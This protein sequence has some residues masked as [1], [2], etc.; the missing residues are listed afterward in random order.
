MPNNLGPGARRPAGARR[1]R[2]KADGIEASKRL[3][4]VQAGRR[5]RIGFQIVLLVMIGLLAFSLIFPTLRLYM[6]Q[7]LQTA[8]LKAQVEAA[9]KVNEE[10]AAQLKRWDDP[11]YVKAQARQRLSFAMPGD[12]TFRVSDPENAPVPPTASLA[13]AP[14][15]HLVQPDPPEQPDPWYAQLWESA[16]IAGNVK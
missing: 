2:A 13:P 5:L 1:L 11:A 15:T 16:V 14:P 9:S 10:L 6:A 3:E 4:A 12:R 8:E 7:Q